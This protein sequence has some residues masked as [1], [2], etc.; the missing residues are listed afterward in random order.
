MYSEKRCD[1]NNFAFLFVHSD[2]LRIK[3]VQI[4]KYLKAML[5]TLQ[6]QS[7]FLITYFICI[8]AVTNEIYQTIL[9]LLIYASSYI[10]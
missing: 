8:S 9:L 2:Q 6:T 4:K 7:I 5:K 3:C 10:G 1:L